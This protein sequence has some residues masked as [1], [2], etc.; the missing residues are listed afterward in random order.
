MGLVESR[1]IQPD[2]SNVVLIVTGAHL[3]AEAADRPLAYELGHNIDLWWQRQSTLHLPVTPLVIS[4]IWFLNNRELQAHPTISIGGPSVNALSAA[5]AQRLPFALLREEQ[6]ALQL[7]PKF[8][9]LRAS[10]W[11]VD[12][13]LTAEAMEIFQRKFVEGFLHAVGKQVLSAGD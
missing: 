8:E 2:A 1:S 6:I 12:H 7:D 3:R 9:D 10:I 4:D 11:G 5:W 13:V